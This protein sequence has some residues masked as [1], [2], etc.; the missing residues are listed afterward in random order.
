MKQLKTPYDTSSLVLSNYYNDGVEG[1]TTDDN[2]VI[3]E[4]GDRFIGRETLNSN[5]PGNV[6]LRAN[7]L[8]YFIDK[9][10]MDAEKRDRERQVEKEKE[11]LKQ[12]KELEKKRVEQFRT[13]YDF[14]FRYG[15]K[16]KIV[17][18]GLSASSNGDGLK[19]NSV[20]HL[21][22]KD[23]IKEGRFKRDANT[24]LCSPKD[25]GKLFYLDNESYDLSDQVVTCSKCL[26]VMDRWRKK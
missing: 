23:A 20:T 26:K 21:F 7:G 14:P 13:S 15:I 3:C 12:K 22:V 5:I 17:M 10:I 18:S 19:R 16:H 24:F 2:V 11:R 1:I 9:E 4:N 8:F 6:Q 25:N